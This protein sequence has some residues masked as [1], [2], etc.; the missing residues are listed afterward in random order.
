[1][2]NK[3]NVTEVTEPD[4]WFGKPESVFLV[5]CDNWTVE[6]Y[7][8]QL[9]LF[10]S[11]SLHVGENDSKLDWI[12]NTASRATTVI[13]SGEYENRIVAGYLM[14]MPNVWWCDDIHHDDDYEKLNTNKLTV[15][16]DWL[17]K[18]RLLN[19]NKD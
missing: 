7:I 4:Y 3:P 1:M 16:V 18:K 10:G 5:G 8:D 17:L 2:D 13:V 14:S 15:P 9:P 6:Q 12:I 11:Y 19:D